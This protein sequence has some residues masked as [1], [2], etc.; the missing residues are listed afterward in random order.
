MKKFTLMTLL[1][2]L[3]ATPLFAAGK[4]YALEVAG[5]ACPFCAYGIEK[6]LNAIQGVE[7][8][9]INIGESRAIVTMQE[10][11]TLNEEQARQAVKE[12]GFTLGSFSEIRGGE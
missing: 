11:A 3:W 6:K 12:A 7:K 1:V 9:E 10:G 8:V 4:Q 2:L 5:L